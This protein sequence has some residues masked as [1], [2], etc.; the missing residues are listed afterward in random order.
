MDIGQTVGRVGPIREKGG[1][2]V[3]ESV[4]C[5]HCIVPDRC[6]NLSYERSTP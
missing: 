3:S 4:G 1:G 2:K 6:L 5:R